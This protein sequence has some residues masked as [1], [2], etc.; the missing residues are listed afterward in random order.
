MSRIS[1]D[2]RLRASGR[3]SV[4][5]TGARSD[6]IDESCRLQD[7]LL[8]P[9][10]RP[11]RKACRSIARSTRHSTALA[12][13]DRSI[14]IDSIVAAS[15]IAITPRA[16]AGCGLRADAAPRTSRR[17][18]SIWPTATPCSVPRSAIRSCSSSC[19]NRPRPVRLWSGAPCR[20]RPARR[21]AAEPSSE[22]I[23]AMANRRLAPPNL[24]PKDFPSRRRMPHG[25][26]SRSRNIRKAASSRRSFRCC[27]GRR[28]RTAAGCRRRRSGT[29]REML[30]MAHIRVLEVATFYTMF[31]LEPVGKKAHVQVCGTT[32]CM[33]RGARG[34]L[35]GLPASASITSR[36]TSRPTAIFPGK[37]SS[38]SAPASTRRWC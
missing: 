9:T 3:I 23:A 31:L 20:C 25:R 26:R 33:L 1:C 18:A 34:D 32:P 37:R 24:Q 28:S 36:A 19:K 4:E 8:R 22:T 15:D 27:G 13:E 30:G 14:A 5:M 38:A 12:S 35:R 2:R 7:H 11:V 17:W 10:A 16:L 6:R 29:S 21:R